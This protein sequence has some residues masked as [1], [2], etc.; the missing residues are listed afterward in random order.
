MCI[1]FAQLRSELFK[2]QSYAVA[3]V[4]VPMGSAQTYP[5]PFSESPI[6]ALL[7]KNTP[8]SLHTQLL[9]E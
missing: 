1:L 7:A 3:I 2:N 9:S 5:Y 8:I 4:P 6:P